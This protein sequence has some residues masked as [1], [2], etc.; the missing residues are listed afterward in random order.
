MREELFGADSEGE[1][2]DLD[3]Q[4]AF[5]QPDDTYAASQDL[6][7]PLSHTL[8]TPILL[9]HQQPADDRKAAESLLLSVRSALNNMHQIQANVQKPYGPTHGDQVMH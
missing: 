2:D 1:E 7:G 6:V 5:A 9:V 3:Q 8:A 4:P